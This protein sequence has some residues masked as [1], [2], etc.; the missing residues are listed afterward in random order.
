MAADWFYTTNKQQSGPVSW[1][2]LRK[3]AA[4]GTL[5]RDDLVWSEGMAE[6]LKGERQAGLF[7]DAVGLIPAERAARDEP[8]VLRRVEPGRRADEPR[9]GGPAEKKA[10]PPMASTGMGTGL[11]IGLGIGLLLLVFVMAGACVIGIIAW[12]AARGGDGDQT[13]R[14]ALGPAVQNDRNFTA[15]AGQ[16]LQVL[17]TTQNNNLFAANL[18]PNLSVIILRNGAIVANNIGFGGNNNVIL[19]VPADD[20]YTVR[21]LNRGPVFADSEVRVIIN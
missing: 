18:A 9:R 16:R 10:P 11:M 12:F 5:K 13:Y 7:V 6:W 14:V 1:D 21:I 4:A 19:I 20:V 8:L 17:V 15:R 3:L 2:E